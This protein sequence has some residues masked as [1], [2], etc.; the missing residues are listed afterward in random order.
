MDSLQLID[1]ERKF[2]LVPISTI[3]FVEED[4]NKS[5][6]Y[7]LNYKYF[8]YFNFESIIEILLDNYNFIKTNRGIYV[9]ID[10]VVKYDSIDKWAFFEDEIT[11]LS[12]R[13]SIGNNYISKVKKY[14]GKEK[15]I[16]YFP[17]LNMR[18]LMNN[19]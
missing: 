16:N 18:A 7:T 4:D 5:S 11:D 12:R 6:F 2:I 15:D 8:H 14:L 10:N 17:K 1:S 3:L 19:T 13:A 9:N